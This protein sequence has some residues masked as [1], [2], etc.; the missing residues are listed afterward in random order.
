MVK[1]KAKGHDALEGPLADKKYK[2]GILEV[3]KTT[4]VQAGDFDTKA[5]LLLDVLQEKGRA[6][7]ACSL[8]QNSLQGVHRK[9]ISNWRGGT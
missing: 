9:K 2:S 6:L 5:I 8:L 1:G 7:E 3:L 4:P